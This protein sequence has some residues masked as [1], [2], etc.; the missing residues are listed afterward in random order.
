M[1]QEDLNKTCE[2]ERWW[3]GIS[4]YKERIKD[5]KENRVQKSIEP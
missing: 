1:T 4:Y 3:I 5:E 2:S